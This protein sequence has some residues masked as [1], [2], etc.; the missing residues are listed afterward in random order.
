MRIQIRPILSQNATVPC[1]SQ[2]DEDSGAQQTKAI[3][4]Q[5]IKKLQKLE[6]GDIVYT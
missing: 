6:R 5:S 3:I 1:I 2:N 4:V